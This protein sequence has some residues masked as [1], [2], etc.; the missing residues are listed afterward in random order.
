[1][2]EGPGSHVVSNLKKSNENLAGSVYK[3]IRYEV[4][5]R[6]YSNKKDR[7]MFCLDY[8]FHYILY[9]LP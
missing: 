6:N 2:T 8:C 5:H 9:F 7:D 4:I 1:M 3:L